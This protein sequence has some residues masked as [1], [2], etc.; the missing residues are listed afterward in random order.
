MKKIIVHRCNSIDQLKTVNNNYGVEIDLRTYKSEIILNHDPYL[1][2]GVLFRDWIKHYNHSHIILNI[3][4]EGSEN[5]IIN[6]MNDYNIDDYFF[7]DQSFPFLIKFARQGHKLSAIRFSEFESLETVISLSGKIDWV[8][9]DYFSF[10]PLNFDNSN[11]L[12]EKNF[13]ICLVSPELQGFDK[14]EVIKV[15]NKIIN[16]KIYFDAVCTKYPSIWENLN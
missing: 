10:L 8:W 4:E 11:L 15:Q 5:E 7:L 1:N 13:K 9:V 6:I 16:E 3:K 2:E 14:S 12:K